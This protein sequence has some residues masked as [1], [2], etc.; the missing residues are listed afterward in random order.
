LR[1]AFDALATL[2]IASTW[3]GEAATAAERCAVDLT[4]SER[5]WL[6]SVDAAFHGD[7][8][9]PGP[10]GSLDGLWRFE[11]VELFVA[12]D[13]GGGPAVEYTE[14]EVSPH[15]H[16]LVL[17]FA[18]VRRRSAVIDPLSVNCRIAGD[19]WRGRVE[20]AR[21]ALPPPPWRA[22]AFAMRGQGRARRYLAATPLPGAK[23]DFHQPDLFPRLSA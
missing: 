3:D 4:A 11:A 19:R 20:L 2:H 22:N 23:P 5:G 6:I 21:A 16:F 9:P 10:P 18:G 13:D 15:G 17:R 8:P 1:T 12:A 14:L 7:P